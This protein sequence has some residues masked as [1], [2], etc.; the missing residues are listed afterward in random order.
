[1][2]SLKSAV[3][4]TEVHEAADPLAVQVF[5]PSEIATA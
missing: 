1:M 5:P 3:V 4:A 2:M